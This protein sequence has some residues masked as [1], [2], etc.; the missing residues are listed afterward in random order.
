MENLSIEFDARAN[1]GD[2]DPQ[3]WMASIGIGV[4]M[5][6]VSGSKQQR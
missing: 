3:K 5:V 2:L 6:F 1:F 4:F